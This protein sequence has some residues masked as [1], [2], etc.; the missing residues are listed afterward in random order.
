MKYYKFKDSNEVLKI[1]DGLFKFVQINESG[2]IV[3][4]DETGAPLVAI[5]GEY[6]MPINEGITETISEDSKELKKEKLYA[7]NKR[8]QRKP[9]AKKAREY[10]HRV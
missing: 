6:V 7:T 1:E 8:T 5:P 9:K 10:N 3:E 4:T 2:R